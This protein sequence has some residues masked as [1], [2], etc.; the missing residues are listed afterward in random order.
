[1]RRALRILAVLALL[2]GLAVA[3]VPVRALVARKLEAELQA[4]GLE[5]VHVEVEQLGLHSLTL[6][7]ISLGGK[8][9]LAL[10]RLTLHFSP[11]ELW[12]GRLGAAE[13]NNVTLS[14]GGMTVTT[15]QVTFATLPAAASEVWKGEWAVKDLILT[16]TP[17]ELPP[18]QGKGVLE[19][20]SNAL[21]VEGS[22]T[23]ADQKTNAKFSLRYPFANAEEMTLKV[24]SAALPWGG[25]IIAVQNAMIP[26]SGKPYVLPVQLRNISVDALLQ[27][28]TGNKASATGT[29]SGKVPLRI[30]PGA[31]PLPQQAALRSQAPGK[32]IMAPEA[33]PGE[34]AQI[35]L[36][37]DLMK[38]FH[39]QLLSLTLDSDQK[40][41]VSAT[42]ALEGNNP[43]VHEGRPVKLNVHLSG[44]VLNFITQNLA[45]QDTQQLLK[46]A[47]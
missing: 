1:M 3:F 12:N 18:L 33:I 38:D 32:V 5:E 19:T 31:Y 34:N 22:F 36:V 6:S 27:P 46:N 8:T 28:L 9:P 16:E 25:G 24:A 13:I 17:V 35:T 44:D 37:R 30:Q 11:L 14:S 29:V 45:A 47:R 7:N 43:A 2:A 39:Y 10:P 15:G 20:D 21:R 40:K 4:R 26:F 42:L 23:S 41:G